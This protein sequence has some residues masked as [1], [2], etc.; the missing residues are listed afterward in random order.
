MASWLDAQAGDPYYTEPVGPQG[1][2]TWVAPDVAVTP[3]PGDT[4]GGSPASYGSQVLDIFKVGVGA[5]SANQ[6]QKNMLDYRR[7]QATATGPTPFGQPS[8]G[9]TAGGGGLSLGAVLIIGAVIVAAV[10]AL[11]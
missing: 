10:A 9:A 5:W 3:Q 8:F 7:W 4:A 1:D 2:G 11:K 6:Q